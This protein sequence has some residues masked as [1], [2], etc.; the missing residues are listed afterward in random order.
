MAFALGEGLATRIRDALALGGNGRNLLLYSNDLSNAAWLTNR[1]SGSVDVSNAQGY[2]VGTTRAA[3]ITDTD[4][5]F[6]LNQLVGA[7]ADH[8]DETLTVSAMMRP[9]DNCTRLGLELRNEG[10]G[11]VK[12]GK[13]SD[14]LSGGWERVKVS[15]AFG[16]ITDKV[17]V[18]VHNDDTGSSNVVFDVQELQLE[19]GVKSTEYQPTGDGS[20]TLQDALD[21]ITAEHG[22][23]ILLPAPSQWLLGESATLESVPSWPS[24]YILVSGGD[25]NPYGISA[26]GSGSVS[27]A[28]DVTVGVM[29][30]GEP[31]NPDALRMKLHRY[32]R[33]VLET[34]MDVER[35]AGFGSATMG[36]GPVR[37]DFRGGIAAE[38]QMFASA[39]MTLSF[40]LTETR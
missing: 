40:G 26:V 12:Q 20:Q 29:V 32:L 10:T 15:T 38:N 16:S 24:G 5:T 37:F 9:V 30:A 31:S 34:M 25:L 39:D 18:I 7:N 14:P 2:K 4:G 13:H 36:A 6:E 27:A 22:D 35:G 8:A 28:Y 33:A 11:F 23:G 17:Q 3:R 19:A 1:G 21:A